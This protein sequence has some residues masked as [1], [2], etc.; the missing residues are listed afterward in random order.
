MNLSKMKRQKFS[1]PALCGD[2][3]KAFQVIDTEVEINNNNNNEMNADIENA[4]EHTKR[5]ND[6]EINPETTSSKQVLLPINAP[7][8][9]QKLMKLHRADLARHIRR[10]VYLT[11]ITLGKIRLLSALSLPHQCQLK[12]VTN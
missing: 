7:I 11:M 8:D 5:E 10:N 2:S 6:N 3:W 9:W 12:A 1:S 4:N